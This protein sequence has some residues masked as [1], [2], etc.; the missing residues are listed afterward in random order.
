MGLI[1]AS[2]MAEIEHIPA[3]IKSG[4]NPVTAADT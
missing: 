2:Y 1:G 4:Y 3:L